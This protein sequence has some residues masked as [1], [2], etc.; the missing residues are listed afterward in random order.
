MAAF[1]LCP[2]MIEISVLSFCFLHFYSFIEGAKSQVFPCFFFASFLFF[3]FLLLTFVF[4]GDLKVLF[5]FFKTNF[6]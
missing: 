1:L 5:S 3:F 4:L 2:Y 6:Y